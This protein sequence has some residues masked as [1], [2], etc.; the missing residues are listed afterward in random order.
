[1]RQLELYQ[2]LPRPGMVEWCWE[3]HSDSRGWRTVALSSQGVRLRSFC[4]EGIC[5][6]MYGA[7]LAPQDMQFDRLISER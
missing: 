7:S 5:K 1:M 2:F 3:Q 6:P 4:S